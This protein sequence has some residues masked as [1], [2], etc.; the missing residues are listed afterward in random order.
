MWPFHLFRKR[1]CKTR[2]YKTL[3]EWSQ[4]VGP[5]GKGSHAEAERLE[6]GIKVREQIWRRHLETLSLKEQNALRDG[7]HPSLSWD[8]AELAQP[9]A[10]ELEQHLKALGFKIAK[11][12]LGLYHGNNLVMSVTFEQ[13]SLT[14]EVQRSVPTYYRGYQIKF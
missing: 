14:P 1:E 7:T 10:V 11:V 6:E 2:E 5:S 3:W 4:D 8:R 12:R 9:V 13:D